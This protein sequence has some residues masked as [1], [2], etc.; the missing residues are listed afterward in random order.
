MNADHLIAHRGW[1]RRYPENTLIAIDAAIQ[2]GARHIE[3]DVQ[4][5]RDGVPVLLHN[6]NLQHMTGSN[7]A[8]H[9]LNVAELLQL[10]AAESSRFGQQFANQSLCTLEQVVTLLR[11]APQVHLY[12]ELKRVAI[13]QFGEAQVVDSVLQCIAPVASQC[14]LISFWV[15]ALALAQQRGFPRLGPV[16]IDWQQLDSS[17]LQAL[18]PAIIFCDRD[19]VPADS[20][21]DSHAWPFAV[22]EIDTWQDAQHWLQ[23]GAR[24]IETFAIGELLHATSAL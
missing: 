17:E 1:Q 12:V 5:S 3:I 15:P 13:E 2:A 6:R 21:L 11:A 22:Y 9:Q 4:L 18:A 7:A 16:L 8:A 19:K 20:R 10:P 24:Q 14:T 23:R